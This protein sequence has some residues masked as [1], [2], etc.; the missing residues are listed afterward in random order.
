MR[1]DPNDPIFSKMQGSPD[2]PGSGM[3]INPRTGKM[4]QVYATYG[5]ADPDTAGPEVETGRYFASDPDRPSTALS[6]AG[7]A[8][9]YYSHDNFNTFDNFMSRAIPIAGLVMLAAGGAGALGEGAVSGQGGLGYAGAATDATG[10]VGTASLTQAPADAL[11]AGAGSTTAPGTTTGVS[12][13]AGGETLMPAA[14]APADATFGGTLT[15]TGAGQFE[16]LS[17]FG[18]AAGGGGA[19]SGGIINSA[20]NFAK[21]NPL[22]TVAG[23]QL[24]AGIIGGIGNNIT[25]NQLMDKKIQADKDLLA[26]KTAEEEKLAEWRRRF[27]QG[28]SYFD[29]KMPFGPA[30]A[31]GGSPGLRR[32]DGTPVYGSGGI[33]NV[34]Q[35]GG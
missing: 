27:I 12:A 24:G 20:L 18:G 6:L 17:V 22:V 10:T 13:G 21:A 35:G 29:A 34:A 4:E 11:N 2:A 7:Y 15:Q 5:Q 3:A 1:Y 14:Q 33:I 16:D 9:G 26:Q 31:G 32:P 28:G 19:A 30:T 23:A 25:Q 8:P